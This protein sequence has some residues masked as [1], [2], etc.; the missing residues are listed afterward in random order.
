MKRCSRIVVGFACFLAFA[1]TVEAKKPNI[2]FIMSDDHT[3]QA[4]GAYGGR[5]A[6]LN[7]T[8]TIDSL[9]TEGIVMENAFCQNSICTPSRA[10]IMTGQSCAVS[11]VTDLMGRLPRQR[12]YLALEMGK[13]GYQTAIVGKWHLKERPLAFH[14]YKVLIEQGHYHDP[15]FTETGATETVFRKATG[16]WERNHFGEFI[17]YE[18]AVQMKGHSTD[19]ITDSA[20]EW[21]KE[22][23]DPSK[24]FFLKLHFKAPHDNFTAAP[25]YNT[26]L[27][28]VDIPEPENL[29]VRGNHGSIATRGHE[30]EL[31]PFIGTS[32]SPRHRRRNYRW[33]ANKYLKHEPDMAVEEITHHSY[34]EYLKKYLRCVKGIDDNLKR[35]FDYLKSEGV[36]DNTVIIYT[37]DQGMYLG[38]HDYQDKRWG[39][40]EGMRM[41]FIVRY[42][43]TIPAGT[44]SDAIVENIDYPPTM[45]DFA[46]VP[47]PDYMHGRSFRA[48]ME[49]GEEPDD[50][51]KAAYYHYWMH[52]A[53]HHNPGHIGIRTKKFKLLFF[54][55]C[56]ENM[57]EAQ[58]PPGWELYDM[59]ND[60]AEMNN[61]YGN[62]EYA[63]VIANLK[64]QLKELRRQYG[65]DDPKYR[66]NEVIDE[67]WDYGLQQRSRAIAISNRFRKEMESK[68]P[69]KN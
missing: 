19:C 14:Y 53:H 26:Y 39:Y 35:V 45:L 51:K 12:Q 18:N 37:G 68:Y 44:R 22:K 3:S 29:W 41:P 10:S 54:Y 59:E 31:L 57:T 32:I 66:C 20:L 60:P 48:I 2:L 46:G 16:N 50:W 5:L 28:D 38:E 65:E 40:E 4:V 67:F 9:T 33:Y 58:T 49:T 56:A 36:Y 64:R 55:G 21:F 23:R 47:T 34:Q 61:L 1:S 30:D 63:E 15:V 7:P 62:S 27:A 52:M 43:K 6:A 24:P 25:R 8:P 11:G 69:P 42:P 13:A 17:K